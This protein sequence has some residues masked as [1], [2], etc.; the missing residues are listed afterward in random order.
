MK[1]KECR[2][3]DCGF[4]MMLRINKK[5]KLHQNL[6]YRS[7]NNTVLKTELGDIYLMNNEMY[8]LTL[9]SPAPRAV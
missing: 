6:H 4:K 9:K 3:S 2:L 8:G 1:N 5:D 7:V